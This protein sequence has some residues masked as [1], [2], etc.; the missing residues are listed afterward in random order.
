[1]DKLKRVLSGRDT[2]EPSD[3]SEVT[4]GA[5]YA[6]LPAGGGGG[7]CWAAVGGRAA[8]REWGEEERKGGEVRPRIAPQPG[9]GPSA[10]VGGTGLRRL[11]PSL[12][13]GL[14]GAEPAGGCRDRRF[15]W[16]RCPDL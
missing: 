10:P 12:G 7:R 4:L 16:S 11:S 1:M 9:R 15:V 3:L 6:C 2:E 14:P 5:P 13:L 8:E